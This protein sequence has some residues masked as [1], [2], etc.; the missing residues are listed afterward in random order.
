MGF[1]DSEKF[2]KK[3]SLTMFL[4]ALAYHSNVL[5]IVKYY[6]CQ[7]LI[8]NSELPDGVGSS[9]LDML[10]AFICVLK[11]LDEKKSVFF[12]DE[13]FLVEKKNLGDFG[14]I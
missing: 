13:K 6:R 5:T 10:E 7:H 9:S 11:I 4:E 2:S 1:D 12:F 14:N 8:Q 3:Y